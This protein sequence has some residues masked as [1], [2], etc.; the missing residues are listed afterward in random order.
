MRK[1]VRGHMIWINYLLDVGPHPIHK[2]GLFKKQRKSV[3][4]YVIY[5]G[6]Y[7]YVLMQTGL[8]DWHPLFFLT[9][10]CIWKITMY[11]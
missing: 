8:D 1:A 3:N 4:F 2:Q 10:S 7:Q 6:G 11:M 5:L 9:N